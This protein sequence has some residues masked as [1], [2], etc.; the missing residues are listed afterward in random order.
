VLDQIIAGFVAENPDASVRQDIS[1][2]NDYRSTALLKI[3]RGGVGDVFT[4]FRGA[5][6]VDMVGAGPYADLS[7]QS[8]TDNYLPKLVRSGRDPQGNQGSSRRHRRGRRRPPLRGTP[9]CGTP[10]ARGTRFHSRQTARPTTTRAPTTG[11]STQPVKPTRKTA[12]IQP[13]ATDHPGGVARW[14]ADGRQDRRRVAR[15]GSAEARSDSIRLNRAW[16]S[17][18]RAT[19]HLLHLPSV[20]GCAFPSDGC[21]SPAAGRAH[22]YCE[23]ERRGWRFRTRRRPPTRSSDGA[24]IFEHR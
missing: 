19:T 12:I 10:T 1:P 13:G 15:A 21:E 7:A 23:E 18:S 17:A 24:S 14:C 9:R 5:Q 2:S 4:A 6:F 20:G 16:S 22:R 3:R 11:E 8:F